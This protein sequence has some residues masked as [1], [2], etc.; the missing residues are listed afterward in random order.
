MIG[1]VASHGLDLTPLRAELA[2]RTD[3]DRNLYVD[4]GQIVTALLGNAVTANVFMV[5]VA[6]QAGLHPVARRGDRAGHRAERHRCRGQPLG[7]PL[8]SALDS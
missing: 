3:A 1:K 8:G 6:Y 5:G 7:V 4:A 2:K